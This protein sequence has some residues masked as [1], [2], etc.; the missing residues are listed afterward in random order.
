MSLKC[1]NARKKEFCLC[2]IIL[3]FYTGCASNGG[4][5]L[6]ENIATSLKDFGQATVEVFT[7]R[8]IQQFKSPYGDGRGQI[9]KR[10]DGQAFDFIGATL[11]KGET[12]PTMT[13]FYSMDQWR[14]NNRTILMLY[15]A[16]D[17]C[18]KTNWLIDMDPAGYSMYRLGNCR[19]SFDLKSEGN[20]VFKIVENNSRDPFVYLYDSDG[21]SE[22]KLASTWIAEQK[23]YRENERQS[24]Y[25]NNQKIISKPAVQPSTNTP[26][27][28]K[29]NNTSQHVNKP[30]IRT[31]E[32]SKSLKKVET[33]TKKVKQAKTVWQIDKS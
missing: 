28:N 17:K 33:S 30:F 9:R 16:S 7:Y 8:D 31:F 24:H 14:Q 5:S 27:I 22:G 12:I 2:F 25:S 1:F 21:L 29:T 13:K 19:N 15:G 3:F 18:D 11:L 10:I 23:A 32:N 20:G 26:S 4:P 6:G